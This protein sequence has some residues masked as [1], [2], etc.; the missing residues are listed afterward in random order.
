MKI[1]DMGT[2]VLRKIMEEGRRIRVMTDVMVIQGYLIDFDEYGILMYAEYIR[3][4]GIVWATTMA[5]REHSVIFDDTVITDEDPAVCDLYHS[6][7]NERSV[8]LQREIN[9]FKAATDT[10]PEN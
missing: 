10:L 4:N 2:Q 6:L 9:E 5:N 8:D 7:V 3:E 1:N